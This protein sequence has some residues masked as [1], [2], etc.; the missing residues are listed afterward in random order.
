MK[1]LIRFTCILVMLIA[2]YG[3]LLA[4]AAPTGIVV[5]VLNPDSVGLYG[6]NF[7]FDVL[8]LAGSLALLIGAGMAWKHS[9]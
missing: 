5:Q 1:T 2:A 9:K 3:V 8:V 7:G 6:D 4:T